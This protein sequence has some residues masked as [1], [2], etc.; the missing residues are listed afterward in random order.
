MLASE[1]RLRFPSGRKY[2]LKQVERQ[3]SKTLHLQQ[4]QLNA[5]R[6]G[7]GPGGAGG[8]A[9]PLSNGQRSRDE[10]GQLTAHVS[11]VVW[12]VRFWRVSWCIVASAWSTEYFR[13]F[14]VV[15]GVFFPAPA[16]PG[17]TYI[18]ITCSTLGG[19]SRCI[20]GCPRLGSSGR[21]CVR[22]SIL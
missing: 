16:G 4:E 13:M 12:C 14:Y 9:R 20:F 19:T 18:S 3:L 10:P 15:R 6:K 7:P 2:G 11:R 21:G 5:L 8:P 1:H 22:W 17:A